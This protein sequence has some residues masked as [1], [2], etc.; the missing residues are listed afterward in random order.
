MEAIRVKSR[1]L[2]GKV[3]AVVDACLEDMEPAWRLVQRPKG[4]DYCHNDLHNG[5]RIRSEVEA[6]K[7][8]YSYAVQ[9]AV[10]VAFTANQV[11]SLI[12]ARTTAAGP[13]CSSATS[14]SPTDGLEGGSCRAATTW[15]PA[16]ASSFHLKP[17]LGLRVLH[18]PNPN[19][20]AV[21]SP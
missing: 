4:W 8:A 18:Y 20:Q 3:K 5:K 6:A 15:Q 12:A 10:R 1:R 14:Q 11:R 21:P 7:A 16:G 9:Q 13:S 17:I 19:R 2:S